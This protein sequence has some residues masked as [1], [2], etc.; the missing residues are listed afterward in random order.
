[1]ERAKKGAT[2]GSSSN[3]NDN[4]NNEQEHLDVDPA[5]DKKRGLAKSPAVD[6]EDTP[7]DDSYDEDYDLSEADK[8][9]CTAVKRNNITAVQQALQNGAN[10]NCF[11]NDFDG[12]YPLFDAC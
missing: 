10:V 11:S 12:S 9:L 1:M 8:K 5:D 4:K 2:T 3:S 7:D 6:A